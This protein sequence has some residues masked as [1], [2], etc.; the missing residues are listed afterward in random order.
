MTE[1]QWSGHEKSVR[2]SNQILKWLIGVLGP[3]LVRWHVGSTMD[4]SSESHTCQATL[5][6]GLELLWDS[7]HLLGLCPLG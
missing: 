4:S 3:G 6:S 1:D 5:L 2:L 7:S